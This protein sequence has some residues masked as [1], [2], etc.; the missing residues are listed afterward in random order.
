M[1]GKHHVVNSDIKDLI[2]VFEMKVKDMTTRF[3]QPKFRLLRKCLISE[4]QMINSSNL[5]F[6]YLSNAV[7]KG[8]NVVLGL[9][10]NFRKS[11]SN[12]NGN[13]LYSSNILAEY[14]RKVRVK[15]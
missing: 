6:S 11:S 13:D 3:P 5:K 8:D 15:I 2:R 4:M 9:V 7:R 14:E 10:K 12:G 1:P